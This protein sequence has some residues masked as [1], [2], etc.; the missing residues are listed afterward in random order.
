M[1]KARGEKRKERR[2]KRKKKTVGDSL[3]EKTRGWK[4]A[5]T[6]LCIGGKGVRSILNNACFWQSP[7]YGRNVA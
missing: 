3:L 2:L 4:E 5:V 1:E 6:A 7:Q